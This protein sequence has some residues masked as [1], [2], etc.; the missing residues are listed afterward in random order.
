M[1]IDVFG[2]FTLE[3]VFMR[4]AATGLPDI[5]TRSI[6]EG[7]GVRTDRS[8]QKVAISIVTFLL[9]APASAHAHDTTS[10]DKGLTA[11]FEHPIL[12]YDHLAMMV[13]IGVLSAILGGNAIW[14]V[15]ATFVA[16]LSLGGAFGIAGWALSGVEYVILISLVAIG[17]MLVGA[18][19][20]DFGWLL[21]VVAVFGFAHGNAHGVEIPTVAEP[22]SYVIGFCFAS[23]LCHMTGVGVGAGLKRIPRWEVAARVYGVAL[24]S[25]AAAMVVTN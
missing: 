1:A 18:R 8:I 10:V 6:T 9:F 19:N 2:M 3:R 17:A 11:G 22:I 24:L 23:S 20:F 12:G 14:T 16:A 7:A 4:T 13:S 5:P 21:T 15:P 25:I